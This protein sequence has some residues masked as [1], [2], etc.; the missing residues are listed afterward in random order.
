MRSSKSFVAGCS[1]YRRGGRKGHG[2]WNVAWK[3]AD[4][5]RR[6]KAI[7][8]DLSTTIEWAKQE[9][10]RVERRRLGL[11][12]T[13]GLLFPVQLTDLAKEYRNV[14]LANGRTEA[15][16]DDVLRHVT[17]ICSL[18]GFDLP[19]K[20]RRAKCELVLGALCKKISPQ[21]AGIAVEELGAPLK[22]LLK[23]GVSYRTRNA[24]LRSMK[25]FTLWLDGESHITKDPLRLIKPLNVKMDRRH[26][27]Q[28]LR[29]D[30]LIRLIDATAISEPSF[31]VP[32]IDRAALYFAAAVTGLRAGALRKM[33][34]WQF[35]LHDSPPGVVE[36]ITQEKAQKERFV[37][38]KR[39]EAAWLATYLDAKTP[40]TPAFRMPEKS[41]VVRMLRRDLERAG[42]PY[43]RAVDNG[44][45]VKRR[46]DVHDFHSLKGS[47]ATRVV[48][49]GANKK[50]L[51][52]LVGHST[53]EMTLERYAHTVTQDSIDVLDRLP[54]LG[55][56]PLQRAS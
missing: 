12:P 34:T 10:A 30:Q 41:N 43:C 31:G 22:A 18:A 3:T 33:K 16:A 39:E 52:D 49:A 45:G 44:D 13:Q 1:I 47:Y 23:R 32:G 4:G 2:K 36:L 5:A 14:I 24:Y 7:S 8:A 9:M 51:I 27:R 17:T 53:A 40:E 29:I 38:L 15:H 42:L 56:A 50:T 19:E 6:A 20:I 35:K 54:A 55:A 48:L 46:I 21:Q 26:E 37:P 11:P 28:G 25:S